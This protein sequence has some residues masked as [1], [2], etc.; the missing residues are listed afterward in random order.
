MQ[1]DYSND[2]AKYCAAL[3]PYFSML[4]TSAFSLASDELCIAFAYDSMLY[5]AVSLIRL[6]VLLLYTSAV[7]TVRI[8]VAFS[9][10]CFAT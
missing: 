6:P 5:F 7:S 8:C 10:V 9:V 2:Y 1:L 3:S 4:F